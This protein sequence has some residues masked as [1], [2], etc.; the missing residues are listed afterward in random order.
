M[1]T[2]YTTTL[3]E[4]LRVTG[5]RIHEATSASYVA[6]INLAERENVT[7]AAEAVR[8]YNAHNELQAVVD[9]LKAW[10]SDDGVHENCGV[11]QEGF[12]QHFPGCPVPLL[13]A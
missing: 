10:C 7:T 11:C 3:P 1:T 8:R 9:A 5:E 2:E 12:E 4:R 6:V 13:P